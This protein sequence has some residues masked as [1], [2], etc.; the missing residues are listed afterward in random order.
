MPATRM[1]DLGWALARLEVDSDGD[2]MLT[3]CWPESETD[4]QV[5]PAGSIQVW[6]RAGL[7]NLQEALS[8]FL[9]DWEMEHNPQRFNEDDD[10]PQ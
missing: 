1:I 5:R 10:I 7:C 6:H 4:T 9:Y 2:A 8:S 3:I